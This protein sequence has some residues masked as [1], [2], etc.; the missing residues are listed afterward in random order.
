[1]SGPVQPARGTPVQLV[2][3]GVAGSGKTTVARA[4]AHRL[5]CP[6][7][8]ADDLH[9]PANVAKM[10]AGIPLTDEDRWPWLDAI[11]AWIR[12][13]AAAGETAVVTCS[14]LKRAYRDVLR[15]SSS[16]ALFVHLT[17]APALLAARIGGR[18]GHFMAPSML[19]SQLATL[20][21]L[22]PDEPGFAV[23]VTPPPD[24]IADA[25]LER[26]RAPTPDP[27]TAAP[28]SPPPAGR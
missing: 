27:R 22:A 14:A 24:A 4:L 25:V 21:P 18:H 23:D 26:L 2:V 13:R 19:E 5:G 3:I 20:E 15:A 1:M 9:P 8:D 28:G 12:A 10:S 16:G 6:F 7:A 17:G 11:A